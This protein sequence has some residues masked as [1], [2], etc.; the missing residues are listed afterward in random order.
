M[1]AHSSSL[2][3]TKQKTQERRITKETE[4]LSKACAKLAQKTFACEADA[5]AELEA[6]LQQNSEAYHRINGSVSVEERTK[7]RKGRGR[8]TKGYTPEFETVWQV[9]CTL[10]ELKADKIEQELRKEETFI[11]MTNELDSHALA[12]SDILRK[13]KEQIYVETKFHWLKDP[14]VVNEV[15]L[16]NNNRVMALGFVFLMGLLVYCLLERR[17]RKN[18]ASET[19]PIRLHGNRL[20]KQPTASAFLQLFTD[21]VVVNVISIDGSVQRQLPKRYQTKELARALQLARFTMDLY[22][23]P[24][25]LM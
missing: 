16:K 9:V 15:W 18:L 21:I 24:P 1:V 19:K 11:L 2:A 22:S 8:P 4:E 13:Y 6:F 14:T 17:I 7:P 3:Q 20:T 25:T 5:K 12:D 23:Y 10:G